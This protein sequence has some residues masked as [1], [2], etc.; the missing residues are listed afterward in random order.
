M[1]VPVALLPHGGSG[2]TLTHAQAR[3]SPCLTCAETPCCSH[4]PVH[5]F[6]VNTLADIDYAAFLLNFTGIELGIDAEGQW[7]VYYRQSCRHLSRD[8]GTCTLHGSPEQPIVCQQYNP[9]QCWYRRVMTVNASAEFLLIDRR[10]LE[11]LLDRVR[12]D[13]H[14]RIVASPAWTELVEAFT[15]LPIQETGTPDPALAGPPAAPG[16]DGPTRVPLPVIATGPRRYA[17]L[18]ASSPCD[19]CAAFCCTRV[20]FPLAT[21]H[22]VASLDFVK[23]SL[24]FPGVTIGISESGWRLI[25]STT[26]RHL[27]GT[28]CS[29]FGSVQ[30]P[31]HCSY[32]DAWRCDFRRDHDIASPDAIVAVGLDQYDWLLETVSLDDG[33]SVTGMPDV[34]SLRL[35]LAARSAQ[36]AAV[37]ETREGAG[38]P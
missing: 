10:R 17:D 19:G 15:E 25:V 31:I 35:H 1:R 28:R 5:R 4:L 23:F 22:S 32:Y 8:D 33:G 13:E 6:N 3:L 24:G 16:P 14:R 7:S 29:V 2:V 12:Y 9:Y 38:V 30:R 34:A 11:W 26:C 27:E 20:E 18:T 36:A 21:P 37:A